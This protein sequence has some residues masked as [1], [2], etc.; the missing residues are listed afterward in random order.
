MSSYANSV[1]KGE[2]SA[3]MHLLQRDKTDDFCFCRKSGSCK[4]SSDVVNMAVK[5]L[6]SAVKNGQDGAARR[7][8]D[9]DNPPLHAD[10]FRWASEICHSES[11]LECF[12][13]LC[14]NQIISAQNLPISVQITTICD[15]SSLKL[16]FVINPEK[17]EY[18]CNQK[19]YGSLRN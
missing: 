17:H 10:Y 3:L 16:D 14:P 19:F 15:L 1:G 6:V 9:K 12:K 7:I 4:F 5:W 13:K 2:L 11:S 8:T 18:P